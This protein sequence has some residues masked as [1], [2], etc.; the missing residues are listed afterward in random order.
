MI[1]I[2]AVSLLIDRFGVSHASA[3]KA[4][5]QLIF[6]RVETFSHNLDVTNLF[7]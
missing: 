4:T 7:Q 1:F 2:F 3:C 5:G 6:C